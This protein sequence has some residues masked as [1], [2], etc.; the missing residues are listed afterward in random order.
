[1]T[2]MAL[3]IM[4]LT[5]NCS[6]VN[7]CAATQNMVAHLGK[8]AGGQRIKNLS[9]LNVSSHGCSSRP[10]EGTQITATHYWEV[11]TLM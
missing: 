9:P 5:V 1:M 10:T 11:P 4:I 6:T 7:H 3:V 2:R 8:V